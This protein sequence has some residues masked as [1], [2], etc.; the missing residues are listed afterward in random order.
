MI[1]SLEVSPNAWIDPRD[2]LQPPY[3][4]PALPLASRLEQVSPLLAACKEGRHYNVER[5]VADGLPIQ[6]AH[7]AERDERRTPSALMLAI[8]SGAMDLALLLLCNGYRTE[9]ELDSPLNTALERRRKDFVLLLLDWGADPGGADVWRI[10]D[11]YDREIFNRFAASDV[12]LASDGSLAFALSENTSNRPLY[13]FVKNAVLEDARYQRPLDIALSAAIDN[14]RDKALSLCLWAGANPRTRV[15]GLDDPP[16]EDEYGAT[17]IERAVEWDRAHYL[18]KLGFDPKLDRP[19]E[20]FEHVY[21]PKA[22]KILVSA[23]SQPDWSMLAER[24]LLKYLGSR[25]YGYSAFTLDDV[26]ETFSMG[27][28]LPS[29]SR[30]LKR[31]LRQ[32]LLDESEWQSPRLFRL[33]RDPENL[34]Q[35]AFISLVAHQKLAERVF[36]WSKNDGVDRAFYE[37]LAGAKGVPRSVKE[38][39]RAVIAPKPRVIREHTRFRDNGQER[40]FSREELYELVWTTPLIQLSARLGISDNAIRKRCRSMLVP[41]PHRGYWQRRAKG[42]RRQPL[43]SLPTS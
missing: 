26:E 31:R 16:E 42:A 10:L 6:L 15:A 14:E 5:W 9:L 20:L 23:E 11:S 25:L 35:E 3:R 13:G 18:K 2:V 36:T 33:I 27:G 17:A 38:K 30:E 39:A 4:G 24:M 40:W 43:P 19:E 37:M 21:G 22:L 12:D 28:F 8:E 7:D 41:T 32:V 34:S 29:L 1:R